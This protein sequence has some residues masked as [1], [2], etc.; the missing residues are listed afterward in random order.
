MKKD[1]L[2]IVDGY[3]WA[4]FN[5]AKALSERLPLSSDIIF[6]K[7][8][9]SNIF[10]NYKIVYSLNWPIH[11]HIYKNIGEK[12]KRK[13]RLYTTISSEI[14]WPNY[15]SFFNILSKY[16]GVSVSSKILLSKIN[17]QFPRLKARLTPFGFDQ[18]TFFKKTDPSE[19][20]NIF[21]WVGNP[22]RD[23]KRFSDIERA[24]KSVPGA[25]LVTATIRS[26]YS[27]DQMNDFYNQIGSIICF[28]KSEGTPNPVLEAAACGRRII[29]TPV[30]NI[31]EIKWAEKYIVHNKK[32]LEHRVKATLNSKE[33][34]FSSESNYLKYRKEWCWD[35][36]SK[37]FKKFLKKS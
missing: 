8:I 13:Y 30:G 11:G 5:R 3:H 17:R 21:G 35:N 7:D 1:I 4:L 29:S 25:K 9:K 34:G 10:N 31:P 16:D 6:F 15:R 18:N 20:K 22:D 24:V 14:N 28:S 12:Q 2:Y 36:R 32:Q 27:R 23:V 37:E 33:I 19:Y 26:G